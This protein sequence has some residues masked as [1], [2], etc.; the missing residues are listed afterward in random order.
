MIRVDKLPQ[1]PEQGWPCQCPRCERVR[2]ASRAI[3]AARQPGQIGGQPAFD[4]DG[5]TDSPPCGTP[6]AWRAHY[7]RGEEPDQAC[8]DAWNTYRRYR[9]KELKRAEGN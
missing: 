3:M 5:H 9:R 7:R 4:Q 6:A 8:R 1:M 2:E